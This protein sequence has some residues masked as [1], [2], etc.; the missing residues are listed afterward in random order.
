MNDVNFAFGGEVRF[1]NYGITAG[2]PE[3]Y[4]FGG[5]VTPSGTIGGS[6]AQ[7][8]PGFAPSDAVRA[9]PQLA[10]RLYRHRSQA[11]RERWTS[12]WPAASRIIQRLRHHG[13]RQDRRALRLQR[14]VRPA[15][16]RV[17]GL[18]RAVAAAG[19]CQLH[20][21][22]LHQRQPRS[23]AIVLR[24]SNPIAGTHRRGA[25]EAG[26]LRQLF[27]GRRFPLGEFLGDPGR[28][29]HQRGQ[30]HRAVGHPHPGQRAGAVPGFGPDRRRALLHQ[31]RGHAS[32]RAWKRSPPTSGPRKAIS[33]TSTSAAAPANNET[34]I[35]ALRSTPQLSALTP[36]PAFLTHY[37]IASLIDGQ[38]K[39]KAD[40]DAPTGAMTGSA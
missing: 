24:A 35:R 38:P 11:D 27:G 18:P 31:W 20:L 29:F 8:F 30:P 37:R 6:G 34:S 10:E 40:A 17:V 5:Y 26:K 9:R 21:H 13:E 36:A 1:E 16:R 4:N 39:W 23:T 3:S 15:W 22:H 14:H 25:A 28:L 2:Q 7:G 12:I 32:R 19:I 33:A